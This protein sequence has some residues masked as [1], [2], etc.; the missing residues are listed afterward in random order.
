[1]LERDSIFGKL[2]EF[3]K[4]IQTRRSNLNESESNNREKQFL[5]GK[6][7]GE[8]SE[9]LFIESKLLDSQ[10]EIANIINYI[11]QKTSISSNKFIGEYRMELMELDKIDPSTQS[12]DFD[13]KRGLVLGKIDCLINL[14]E[15]LNVLGNEKALKDIDTTSIKLVD[16]E[17]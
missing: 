9:I 8:F 2:R 13:Y 7:D 10:I 15:H 4:D 12:E 3:T 6:M 16:T 11:D 14:K 1:M 17:D 5:S